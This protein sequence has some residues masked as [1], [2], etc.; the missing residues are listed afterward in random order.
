M[1]STSGKIR[2]ILVADDEPMLAG[3]VKAALEHDGCLVT[4]CRDGADALKARAAGSYSA[5]ILDNLMPRKTGLEVLRA[6]RE[7]GDDVP[8]VLMSSHFSDATREACA[9]L[10]RLSLLQKPFDL[11]ELRDAVDRAV[12]RVKI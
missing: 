5:L 11:A 7:G 6:L 3:L 1:A 8:V 10:D 9:G 4:V 2:R 12:S